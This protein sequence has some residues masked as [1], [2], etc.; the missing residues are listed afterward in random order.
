M[1]R[2]SKLGGYIN[3]L[4]YLLGTALCLELRRINNFRE[5][6]NLTSF[7]YDDT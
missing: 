4:N 2:R 6:E 3:S 5:N 7:D 1:K